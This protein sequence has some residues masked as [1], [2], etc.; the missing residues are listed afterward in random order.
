MSKIEVTSTDL[1]IKN[2]KKEWLCALF[3]QLFCLREVDIDKPFSYYSLTHHD[4][5]RLCEKLSEKGWTFYKPLELTQCL[6]EVYSIG[7]MNSVKTL[8]Q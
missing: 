3:M 5:L 2:E 7:L 1:A 6:D 4:L 8:A